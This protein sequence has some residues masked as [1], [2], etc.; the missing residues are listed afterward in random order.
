[1]LFQLQLI[2]CLLRLNQPQLAL[3][4]A[5]S[6]HESDEKSAELE[7]VLASSQ[8]EATWH[9]KDWGALEKMVQVNRILSVSFLSCVF[10]LSCYG[11]NAK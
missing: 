11:Q 9:L 8:L 2:K 1:M 10:P 6:F 3:N 5:T 4:T 7:S